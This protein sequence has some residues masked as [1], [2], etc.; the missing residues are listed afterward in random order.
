MHF[1]PHTHL[2]HPMPI[3]ASYT[4]YSGYKARPM[5]QAPSTLKAIPSQ[6]L[7]PLQY[8]AITKKDV[9]CSRASYWRRIGVCEMEIK[10]DSNGE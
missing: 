10:M 1:P 9:Q 7:P 5:R 4:K 8:P 2:R 6:S 3:R